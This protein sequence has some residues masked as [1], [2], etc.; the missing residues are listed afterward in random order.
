MDQDRFLQAPQ[1]RQA[2][3]SLVNLP[4][5]AFREAERHQL[6]FPLQRYIRSDPFIR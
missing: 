3:Q 2:H 4:E 1:L 6:G 5:E